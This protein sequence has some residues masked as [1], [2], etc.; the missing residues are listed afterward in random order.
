MSDKV[1][2]NILAMASM[3]F[4]ASSF[5]AISFLLES[6]HP[7]IVTPV[8]LFLAGLVPLAWILL[9]GRAGELRGLPWKDIF[10]CGGIFLGGSATFIIW[11]QGLS[12]AITAS[13]ITTS[14]PL[15]AA[16]FAWMAA[17]AR[18]SLKLVG[19]ILLAIGGGAFA[20]IA[21]AKG[22]L[23]FRGGELLVLLAIILFVLYSRG[24]LK[25]LS[26][27][28]DMTKSA[29]TML[30][31]AAVVAPLALILSL[32]GVIEPEY[33]LSPRSI[34]LVIWMAPIGYALANIF[35][36]R[37]SRLL[38]VTVAGIHQNEIPFFVMSML[39]LFGGEISLFHIAGAL[40][41]VAGAWIAQ[42]K[43]GPKVAKEGSPS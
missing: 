42:R 13:I 33:D 38:G 10:I 20:T 23:G 28:R 39:V 6:W 37:A 17:E 4:W 32:S 19:G 3:A 18:L 11:G 15:I 35:W 27:L 41:V 1:L 5:V 29:V 7:L 2:G 14:M 40:L 43:S 36:I 26:G 31:G 24:A 9:Q 30:A 21:T 12:D 34:G 25:R 22:G 8:R 16:L